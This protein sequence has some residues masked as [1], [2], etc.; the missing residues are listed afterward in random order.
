MS[1]HT[2]EPWHACSAHDGKCPCNGVLAIDGTSIASFFATDDRS[3]YG[4]TE[5]CAGFE[6]GHANRHRAV[7]CVNACAGINPEAVPDLLAVCKA[8]T[9]GDG[10]DP[11]MGHTDEWT[12]AEAFRRF[13]SLARAA[14]AKAQP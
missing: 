13:Q 8:I 12:E 4:V 7:S 3:V 6:E 14:I 9:E 1:E 5:Q 11:E 10:S 2:P